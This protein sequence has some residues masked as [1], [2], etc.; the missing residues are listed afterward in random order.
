MNDLTTYRR[1]RD[2]MH[3]GDVI[4]FSSDDILGR[5]IRLF[6]SRSH[7]SLVVR[8][9]DYEGREKRRFVLEAHAIHGVVPVL[10]SK[11]LENYNG[12]AWWQPLRDE[13][14]LVR[15]HIGT[16]AFAQI[17]KKY[18][19]PGLLASALGHVSENAGAFFCSEFAFMAARCGAGNALRDGVPG[20]VSLLER[21]S[22]DH[23]KIEFEAAW[24]GDFLQFSHTY[25]TG[26]QLI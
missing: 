26:G 5:A 7:V 8:L 19:Y 18:D 23:R 15:R 4:L 20:S 3:T 24:P 10:L 13:F 21:I 25:R 9:P 6:T 22:R 1:K 17:G 2:D 11:K 14:D 16:W 12:R